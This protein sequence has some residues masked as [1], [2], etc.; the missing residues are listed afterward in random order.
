[1][2]HGGKYPAMRCR[3]RS[4]HSEVACRHGTSH[5]KEEEEE[6]EEEEEDRPARVTLAATHQEKQISYG[7]NT[8]FLKLSPAARGRRRRRGPLLGREGAW[9]RRGV[10]EGRWLG[11]GGRRRRLLRSGT[12]SCHRRHRRSIRTHLAAAGAGEEETRC[13]R[14]FPPR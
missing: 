11:V 3:S 7:R 4:R 10:E 8:M 6:E 2:Q 13:E 5:G 1:M 14:S 12:C 9:M